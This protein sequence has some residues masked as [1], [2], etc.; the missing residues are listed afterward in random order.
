MA[1]R[2]RILEHVCMRQEAAGEELPEVP[3]PV[4]FKAKHGLPVL[5]DY[6][7]PIFPADYWSKWVKKSFMDYGSVRSWVDPDLLLDLA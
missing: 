5:E 2:Q 3:A 7:A 4:V 6:D 1:M